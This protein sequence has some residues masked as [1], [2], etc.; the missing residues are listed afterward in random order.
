VKLDPARWP[1]RLQWTTLAVIAALGLLGVVG[2][3]PEPVWAGYVIVYPGV[4]GAFIWRFDRVGYGEIASWTTPMTLV[5]TAAVLLAPAPVGVVLG[6]ACG[7]WLGA[8][9]IWLPPVRWWYRWVL[10]RPAPGLC[11]EWQGLLP[12]RFVREPAAT[13]LAGDRI[14]EADRA[15]NAFIDE[16]MAGGDRSKLTRKATRLAADA[17][18]ES[19]KRGIWQQAWAARATWLSA[20]ASQLAGPETEAGARRVNELAE[21][22]GAALA[23]ALENAKKIDPTLVSADP[24]R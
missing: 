5:M 19:R 8:F 13:R 16:L 18:R 23:S 6:V 4:I 14:F 17:L 3:V 24:E 10:H 12:W 1:T 7:V 22:Y 9:I 11:G 21:A 2:L 20:L 15:S